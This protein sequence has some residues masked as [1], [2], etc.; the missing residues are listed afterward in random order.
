MGHGPQR[1]FSAPRPLTQPLSEYSWLRSFKL[2]YIVTSW[3]R[4]CIYIYMITKVETIKR[5]TIG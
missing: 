1:G 5:Q 2:L 4:L 3:V